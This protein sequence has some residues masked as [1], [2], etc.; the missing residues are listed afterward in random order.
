MAWEQRAVDEVT[1]NQIGRLKSFYILFIF[2]HSP[3]YN[4]P[5]ILFFLKSQSS[6][7]PSPPHVCIIARC[8]TNT[9]ETWA[10][11]SL[12]LPRGLVPTSYRRQG[13]NW[14]ATVL[15]TDK[16]EILS[17][18]ES[19]GLLIPSKEGRTNPE[20]VEAWRPL[21]IVPTSYRQRKT[22]WLITAIYTSMVV[23]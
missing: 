18:E 23:L 19:S 13:G 14:L 11:P 16:E 9:I 7:D 6:R 15:Y 17:L 10:P 20:I 3:E 1:K 5:R 8:Q 21:S 12:S 2:S 22:D 4:I